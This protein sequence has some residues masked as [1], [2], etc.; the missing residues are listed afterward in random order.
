[1]H[2]IMRIVGFHMGWLGFRWFVDL[3]TSLLSVHLSVSVAC[4]NRMP[5]RDAVQRRKSKKKKK[6]MQTPWKCRIWCCVNTKV[7][8]SKNAEEMPNMLLCNRWKSKNENAEEMPGPMLG[9]LICVYVRRIMKGW[10]VTEDT[11]TE[12]L[13]REYWVSKAS[14]EIGKEMRYPDACGLKK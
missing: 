1:M 4:K 2:L 10:E 12:I 9:S 14:D 11:N 7:K 8:K 6:N 13:R 5:A 3:K